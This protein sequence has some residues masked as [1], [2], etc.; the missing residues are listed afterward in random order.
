ME[1]KGSEEIFVSAVRVLGAKKTAPRFLNQVFQPVYQASTVEELLQQAEKLDV[2]LSRFGNVYEQVVVGL[3]AS[4]VRSDW[5]DVVVLLKEKPRLRA[6]TGME[7]GVGDG[8]GRGVSIFLKKE[9][10]PKLYA[11]ERVVRQC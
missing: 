6:S 11:R 10:K 7:M 2:R 3:D 4:K 9:K 1:E 5:V 8:D